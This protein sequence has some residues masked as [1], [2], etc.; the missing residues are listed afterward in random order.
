MKQISATC[1]A[2]GCNRAAVAAHLSGIGCWV[3]RCSKHEG[4]P[5]RVN[6]NRCTDN[7]RGK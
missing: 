6:L 1:S 7:R 5:I 2:I 4:K 3:S